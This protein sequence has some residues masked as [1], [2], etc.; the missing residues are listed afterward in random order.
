MCNSCR[1]IPQC[2]AIEER[3]IDK[4]ELLGVKVV[5]D[6]EQTYVHPF[7]LWTAYSGPIRSEAI[8]CKKMLVD[9]CNNRKRRLTLTGDL[10]SD[11]APGGS[12]VCK[13]IREVLEK[14][15]EEGQSLIVNEYGKRTTPNGTILT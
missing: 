6:T 14:M 4:T 5:G 8:K 13:A 10:N 7:E 11:L 12:E 9:L 3:T 1:P 15:E 2:S